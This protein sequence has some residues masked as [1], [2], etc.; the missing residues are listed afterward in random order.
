MGEYRDKLAKKAA[1]VL[2]PDEQLLAAARVVTGRLGLAV[3]AAIGGVGAT[4]R[5]GTRQGDDGSLAQSL[6]LPKQTAIGLTPR[7]MLF[8]SISEWTG[9]AKAVVAEM[10]L[11]SLRAAT[12][13]RGKV[14]GKLSLSL[15]DGS[16]LTFDSP[17]LEQDDARKL[18]EQSCLLVGGS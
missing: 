4:D 3:A 10:P 1:T 6:G 7:R 9:G 14:I 18:A 12:F 13:E 2:E 16:A 5:Q 8:W 15:V 11:T 17:R